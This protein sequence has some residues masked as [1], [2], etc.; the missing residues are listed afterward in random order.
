[1]DRDVRRNDWHGTPHSLGDRDRE[2]L[3]KRR[4]DRDLGPAIQAVELVVVD[5]A[6]RGDGAVGVGHHAGELDGGVALDVLD[7]PDGHQA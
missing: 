2:A 5:M 1:M 4:H 7:V 3:G 6:E